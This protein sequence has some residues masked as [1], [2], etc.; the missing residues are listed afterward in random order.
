MKLVIFSDNHRN[1]EN[2]LE[3]MKLEQDVD[4]YLSL[5]DSEMSEV[6]LSNLGIIGVRGNYPFEPAFPDELLFDFDG[7]KILLVHGHLLSVK[8]GVSRLYH[9]GLSKQADIACF[10]HTHI[11]YLED[12]GEITLL[13]PGSIAMPKGKHY[14]SYA[15]MTI[16]ERKCL[17]EIIDLYSHTLIDSL[18]I[19]RR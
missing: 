15:R 14:P 12:L 3:M 7:W 2:I 9:Y 19:T 1:R 8:M 18:T 6:E 11:P 13:N 16:T 10:G 4:R 5:G 17:I